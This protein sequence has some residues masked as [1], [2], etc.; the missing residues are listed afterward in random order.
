MP[1]PTTST[2]AVAAST[3][4]FRAVQ[5]GGHAGPEADELVR[6]LQVFAIDVAGHGQEIT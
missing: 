1:S 5:P 6:M 4:V 2:P 3:I